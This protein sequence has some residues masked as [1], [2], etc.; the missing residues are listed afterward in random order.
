[1]STL[2]IPELLHGLVADAAERSGFDNALVAAEP[3]Q[4]TQNPKFGDYQSNHA[5]RLAARYEPALSRK[6]SRRWRTRGRP[7][8]LCRG[9][10]LHQLH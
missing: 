4:P 2:R 9:A 6:R 7:V 5:F 10:G 3:A 1:M 8:Y